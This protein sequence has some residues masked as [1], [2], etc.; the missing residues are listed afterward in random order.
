MLCVWPNWQHTT[1]NIDSLIEHLFRNLV[2]FRDSMK[3][4]GLL[5]KKCCFLSQVHKTQLTY[6]DA[7]GH[8]SANINVINKIIL[9]MSRNPSLSVKSVFIQ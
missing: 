8:N 9:I 3:L 5:E 1:C 2:L 7:N 4:T 6:V